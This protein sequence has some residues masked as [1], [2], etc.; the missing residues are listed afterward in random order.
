APV[1]LSTSYF[2]G[3]ESFGISMTTLISCGGLLPV[4]MW[5]RAIAV[6]GRRRRGAAVGV[7]WLILAGSCCDAASARPQASGKPQMGNAP[8]WR[9]PYLDVSIRYRTDTNH[10]PEP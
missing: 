7:G 10:R 5:S 8:A 4:G 6:S 1:C 2:T 9:T 3:S